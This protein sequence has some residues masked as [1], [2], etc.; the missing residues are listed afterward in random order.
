[1]TKPGPEKKAAISFGK[2]VRLMSE[3][4]YIQELAPFGITQARAFRS[5]CRSICCPIIFMG[6]NAFVDPAVFQICIKNLSMPGNDDFLG[7]NSAIKKDKKTR[8]HLR[9]RV[10]PEE[11]KENWSYVIR[12]IL[13]AR[14][15]VGLH[16]PEAERTAI[17]SAAAELTRFVLTMIPA[18][19]QSNGD[20]QR[21]QSECDSK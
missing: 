8:P 4:Y 9:T 19:E 10:S 6:R 5:L 20:T 17:R 13:D 15:L 12:A 18:S 1:M 2:G 3:E 21:V 7:P 11:I 14:R 16:T